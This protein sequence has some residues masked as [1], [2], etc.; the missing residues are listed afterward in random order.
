[1]HG[2][3]HN[4]E[5]RILVIDDN[6]AV[7]DD[8]RKILVDNDY[9]SHL[10]DIEAALF[11]E[12]ISANAQPK[13]SIVD[14]YQGR[15]GLDK[16]VEA[17][18]MGKPFDLAF[19]DMRMPPG[20]DGAETIERIW[21]KD[22][23]LQIVI[24]TAYSDYSW[25]EL[26]KRLGG[27]DN[28]L[29]L[30]KP[31]DNT[32]VQQLAVALTEKR[33]LARKA[34]LRTDELEQMVEERTA[35]L[36]EKDEQLRQKQKLEAIGSLAG[37]VAHE[38]NNLLQ[39]IRGYNQFAMDQLSADDQAYQ[40]LQQ[41]LVA[42]DRAAALTRQLLNFSRRESLSKTAV[43]LNDVVQAVVK[44]MQPVIGERI[45]IC[46]DLDNEIGTVLA[47]PTML[48][49]ALMNLSIN[50]R[51][52]MPEGGK[53]IV[54]TDTIAIS[55]MYADTHPDVRPGHYARII[56][57]DTGHGMSPEVR[58]R[59]FEPFFTTKE[60]GKGTGLGLAMVY[61]VVTEHT[62][63]VHVYSEPGEGTTFRIYLPLQDAPTACP[64]VP[65][66]G[67]QGGTE[68]ILVAEDE[69]LVRDTAIRILRQAGYV[70]L[71]AENGEE[72]VRLFEENSEIVSL[73]LLDLVMPRMSGRDAFTRMKQI[74]P[75]IEAI[76]CTGYDPLANQATAIASDEAEVIEKP[77]QPEALL[78]A[79]RNT[80]DAPLGIP[81]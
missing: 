29:I 40:D 38:F 50:S 43:D 52:A 15:E 1:M 72:A 34:R 25:P 68:T 3:D 46:T 66:E 10:N 67:P 54:R 7:H 45:Q 51:D 49:Q 11:R 59:I 28:L 63:A 22:P 70:T 42:T 35:A 62:G 71:A 16:V 18:D 58:Q 31:F 56:I 12:E 14:A 39:A 75:A 47:D 55:E 13:Y 33:D 60:V 17:L 76:F 19:I 27:S 2:I 69:P 26:F 79:I 78:H 8:F 77:F 74:N 6:R 57:T 36:R 81:A 48:Q 64:V 20:W 4:R 23:D 32:E 30:K 80:L 37:G 41:S 73:A 65:M 5:R 61:G 53:L 9:A 24:C 21:E 44:M